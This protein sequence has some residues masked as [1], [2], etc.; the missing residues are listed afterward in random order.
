MLPANIT[1]A[2]ISAA[3]RVAA[4]VNGLHNSVVA[5]SSRFIWDLRFSNREYRASSS[6][7]YRWQSPSNLLDFVKAHFF[8][9][10]MLRPAPAKFRSNSNEKAL[11]R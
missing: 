3:R 8:E 2:P 4:L 6:A 1:A 11:A 5:G 10:L 7:K 9:R